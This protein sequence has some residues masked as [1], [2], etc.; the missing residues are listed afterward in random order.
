MIPQP[1]T[2]LQRQRDEANHTQTFILTP[3]L[4]LNSKIP[5]RNPPKIDRRYVGVDQASIRLALGVKLF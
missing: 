5:K 2:V 4:G 1:R 3:S